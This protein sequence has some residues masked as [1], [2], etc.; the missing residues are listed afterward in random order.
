MK[1]MILILSLGA[2]LFASDLLD[3]KNSFDK[4]QY[5]EAYK[6]FMKSAHD[7][8]IA[9]FNIAYMYE[10]GL[11]IKKNMQNAIYFYKLS[12]NDGYDVAQNNLGNAYLKGLGVEKNVQTAIYYYN[13]AA[14]QKNKNAISSLNVIKVA[15]KNKETDDKKNMASLTIRS[16]VSNDKVYINGKYMG[17]TKLIVPL[18]PNKIHKIEVKKDG[19]GT[20]KFKDVTLKD[21]Q[22][23]TI[24]AILK[25]K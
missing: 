8:M 9:K 19:Y 6:L 20:Y 18:A 4:K 3:G 13:L 14:K 24:K 17:K 2:L 15:L 12:A 10:T 23:K 16:N 5:N 7:G 25:R 22:K 21:K 11:G 1:K